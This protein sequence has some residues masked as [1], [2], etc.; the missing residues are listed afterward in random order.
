[1]KIKLINFVK[2]NKNII[3]LS[4]LLCF[5]FVLGFSVSKYVEYKNNKFNVNSQIET[6]GID[7]KDDLEII[8][9]VEG[10]R[11]NEIP[12]G[13]AYSSTVKI[14]D[15]VQ[16][17]TSSKSYMTCNQQTK[18]WSLNLK[19]VD[20]I[21]KKIR[22]DFT[23]DNIPDDAF[24]TNFEYIAPTT[25]VAEPYYTY[26]VYTTGYYKLETWGGSG[27]KGGYGGY[28]VGIAKLNEGD[29]LYVYVGGGAINQNGG[30]NGG[31]TRTTSGAKTGGGGGAT[32]IAMKSGLLKSLSSNIDSIVIVSGGGAGFYN[33][34][35]HSHGGGGGYLGVN[36]KTGKSSGGSCTASSGSQT[37]A[38]KSCGD[39]SGYKAGFGYGCSGGSSVSAGGAGF[40]GGGCGWVQ[41]SDY[42]GGAGGS[43]YINSSY[44]V[45]GKR[46]MFCYGCTESVTDSTF[47]I[48]TTGVSTIR[49]PEN[50]SSGYASDPVSKCAKE[51]NGHARITYLNNY[52]AELPVD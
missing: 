45:T 18:K 20:I 43:G 6:V 12:I 10:I 32:H 5:M 44:L 47:T 9:Y 49:D 29:L 28:S 15:G 25:D 34:T 39:A 48:S 17:I 4:L 31:G 16:E 26:R 52:E 27:N 42:Y 13:C 22:L 41:G 38:G 40:Y 19:D 1:M 8:A 21:P 11:V 3:C 23:K 33:G 14:F 7:D 36:S 46:F 37:A 51:G 35:D 24:I 50:C 2:K 30:Y